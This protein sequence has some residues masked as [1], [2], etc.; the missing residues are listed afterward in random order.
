MIQASFIAF[1]CTT[2]VRGA[3]VT[4]IVNGSFVVLTSPDGVRH[5]RSDTN[6]TYATQLGSFTADY[7]ATITMI[8]A[9]LVDQNRSFT[10]GQTFIPLTLEYNA[11]EGVYSKECTIDNSNSTSVTW[12]CSNDNMITQCDCAV[13]KKPLFPAAS[14]RE[15]CACRRLMEFAIGSAPVQPTSGDTNMNGVYSGALYSTPFPGR[16]HGSN[17]TLSSVCT[18]RIVSVSATAF[19]ATCMSDALKNTVTDPSTNKSCVLSCGGSNT[20]CFQDCLRRSLV[21]ILGT[22]NGS[23][24]LF[25][26]MSASAECETTQFPHRQP[27][28]PDPWSSRV[29]SGVVNTSLFRL[30]PLGF[31]TSLDNVNSGVGYGDIFFGVAEAQFQCTN[32]TPGGGLF[33]CRSSPEDE[34][35][36]LRRGQAVYA[37]YDV[38]V[39][40]LFGDYTMCNAVQDDSKRYTCIP[41]W[42]CS[43]QQRTGALS[44]LVLVLANESDCPCYAWGAG[45]YGPKS[46][47]KTTSKVVGAVPVEADWG[48]HGD[49]VAQRNCSMM[50]TQESCQ[51][52]SDLAGGC[53]WNSVSN[54]CDFIYL[55]DVALS[56]IA[57]LIGGQWYSTQEDGDCDKVSNGKQCS[58]RLL[59]QPSITNATCVNNYV[60]IAVGNAG[61]NE[62]W[63]NTC[64]GLDA[65]FRVDD[66]WVRCWQKTV[67]GNAHHGTG[68]GMTAAELQSAFLDGINSEKCALKIE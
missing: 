49:G 14:M 48:T 58:W 63:L 60:N 13:Y 23:K 31:G 1:W 11:L 24:I 67:L 30:T 6:V 22:A 59:G 36:A 27:F 33:M 18:W 29:N 39:N 35:H 47:G 2:I 50:H 62:C 46:G 42:N 40:S 55:V 66:C 65:S 51:N 3:P 5:L 37:K 10:D 19:N 26:K 15:N 53:E 28:E 52:S 7:P 32:S 25:A 45:T 68:P 17:P 4:S 64:N 16:C 57:D 41:E 9:S 56:A 12:T 8:A 34:G 54:R 44:D 38:E 43:C 61:A 21:H 20:Q